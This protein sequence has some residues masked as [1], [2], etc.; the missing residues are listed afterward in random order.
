[1][2]LL[3]SGVLA[4]LFMG[5][6]VSDDQ[7]ATDTGLDL[8]GSERLLEV[9]P[10]TEVSDVGN[11]YCISYLGQV[12]ETYAYYQQALEQA[13]WKVLDSVDTNAV[14]PVARFCRDDGRLILGPSV[15]S[16]SVVLEVMEIGRQNDTDLSALF[17]GLPM[18]IIVRRNLIEGCSE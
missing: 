11:V 14:L 4:L 13:G 18:K 1:M 15:P 5:A 6:P 3:L 8:R 9:C 12:A 17:R 10:F 2:S 16:A 7:F